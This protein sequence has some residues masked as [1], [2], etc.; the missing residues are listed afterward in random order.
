MRIDRTSAA[1]ADRLDAFWDRLNDS[2]PNATAAV[3]ARNREEAHLET[4]VLYLE[5]L[6]PT[7]SPVEQAVMRAKVRES[8]GKETPMA[9]P[10]VSPGT[11]T[12]SSGVLSR[13][14]IIPLVRAFDRLASVVLILAVLSALVLL[15][16]VRGLLDGGDPG[17]FA[18]MLGV[19]EDEPSGQHIGGQLSTSI[20]VRPGDYEGGTVEMGLWEVTLAPGSAMSPAPASGDSQSEPFGF[21]VSQ[22]SVLF[23]GD[24]TWRPVEEGGSVGDLSGIDYVRNP[25]SS[26]AHL[27]V[28]AP[29]PPNAGFPLTIGV[30]PPGGAVASP[31][32]DAA[33][34]GPEPVLF[35]SVQLDDESAFQYRV[36]VSEHVFSPGMEIADTALLGPPQSTLHT[37]SLRDGQLTFDVDGTENT[38][39]ATQELGPG[40]TIRIENKG[41]IQ[42]AL[43]VTG[44][45]SAR[46]LVLSSMPAAD[47]FTLDQTLES[48]APFWGEW[49]VPAS[50]E[51]HLALRRLALQPGGTYSLPTDAGVLYHVAS[52][53]VD[54][55]NSDSGNTVNVAAGGTVAQVPGTVLTFSNPGAV[56]VDVIQALVFDGPLESIVASESMD[57]VA[58]ET[59]VTET[60]TLPAGE[61][62]LMLEVYEYNGEN[63][64]GASGEGGPDL[65]LITS[66]MGEIET[67]RLGGDARVVPA[68]GSDGFQPPLG[69]GIGIEPGGYLL[70]KP[71]AG[72]SITGASGAPSTG[73]V[74]SVSPNLEPEGTPVATPV[75]AATE[76]TT[77]TGTAD[78]CEIAPLTSDLVD[79]IVATPSAG[80]APLERSLRDQDGGTTDPAAMD[81]VVA[82]L[83]GYA[84]CN[85]TGE[86]ARIYAFYTAQAIRESE[87]IQDLV[88]ID[89]DAGEPARNTTT[90]EE[91]VLFPDGRAGARTVIDGQ[92]AYLTFVLED[93]QW[94]I[95]VWDDSGSGLLPGGTPAG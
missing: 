55:L 48:I 65:A 36:L 32:N 3:C 8:I 33:T 7:P 88:A 60:D 25:N 83:Q 82:M 21:A 79:S 53:T 47:N 6:K 59:L 43:R 86:Y 84:D 40:N 2:A 58:I 37:I 4:L 31:V 73:L 49:T 87:V 41:V 38:P 94:K 52:G 26:A 54:I 42:P 30:W 13:S 9:S 67:S 20:E 5:S 80:S 27:L 39:Q 69:E 72:W 29:M 18:A 77:L 51:V 95:D 89:H 90:V 35:G 91:I 14:R 81:G 22:G 61:A 16:P 63:D 28:L 62:S 44:T 57:R 12:H 50:G 78:A 15:G 85:A 56:S 34:I 66:A 11:P 17:R 76:T 45:E 64:G 46:V 1:Q 74:L 68:V 10:I 71:D 75:A 93:G 70:A 23:G 19:D 24:D 92:P